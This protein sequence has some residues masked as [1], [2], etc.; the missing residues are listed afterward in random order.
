MQFSLSPA[1]VN[2]C[3]VN[4]HSWIFDNNSCLSVSFRDNKRQS[5]HGNGLEATSVVIPAH[6]ILTTINYE[7][8]RN[9][10]Q[11]HS[12]I[13]TKYLSTNT[14]LRL[15]DI[16]PNA[17]YHSESHYFSLG[18]F[19]AILFSFSQF[20][21]KTQRRCLLKAKTHPND[22]GSVNWRGKLQS[23][24]RCLKFNLLCTMFSKV[25][26]FL[27]K[28]LRNTRDRRDDNKN[29][30]SQTGFSRAT[31]TNFSR[32]VSKSRTREKEK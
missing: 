21:L 9:N 7:W 1:P 29:R 3:F 22:P 23:S 31:E 2:E 20:Q 12:T 28:F 18:F 10:F 14:D 8:R 4:S 30:S 13:I 24:R 32:F 26:C 16:S 5:F 6:V 15:I 19:F 17:F 25:W 27:L 11:S